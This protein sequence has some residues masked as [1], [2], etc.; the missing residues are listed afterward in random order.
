MRQ[1]NTMLLQLSEK[2]D[3]DEVTSV[4]AVMHDEIESALKRAETID[5]FIA[6]GKFVQLTIDFGNV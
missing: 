2:S 3:I 5:D 6:D 4:T 1:G